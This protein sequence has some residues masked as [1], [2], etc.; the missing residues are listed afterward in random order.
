[1]DEIQYPS[2]S[3]KSRQIEQEKKNEVVKVTQGKVSQKPKSAGKRILEDFVKEDAKTIKS[4]ILFDIIVPTI[5]DMI[6][7][8]F[9]A[10]L[11]MLLYGDD[12]TD[13]LEL[14]W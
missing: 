1:M 8:G 10:A 9:H 4:H 2:N 3:I 12:R 5:K 14:V 6:S 7:S 11:D 13:V